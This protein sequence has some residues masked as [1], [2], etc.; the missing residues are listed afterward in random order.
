MSLRFVGCFSI[1]SFSYRCI[2]FLSAV[3]EKVFFGLAGNKDIK[4]WN[5]LEFRLIP[6]LTTE[7]AAIECLKIDVSTFSEFWILIDLFKHSG[8]EEVPNVL[9]DDF[10]FHPDWTA[11][12][13]ASCP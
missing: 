9:P 10:D 13:G 5:E 6:P 11:D 3:F 1:R 8:N 7:L 2:R 4:A 12:Y